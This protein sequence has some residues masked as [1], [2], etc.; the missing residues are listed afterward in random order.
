KDITLRKEGERAI[1][2]SE[3]RFKAIFEGAGMGI[4]MIDTYGK[5]IES[6]QALEDFLGYSKKELLGRAIIDFVHPDDRDFENRHFIFYQGAYNKPGFF[7]KRYLKRD[8]S[9]VWG[10]LTT[11]VIHDDKGVAE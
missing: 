2:A 9:V 7:E 6:N 3:L 4:A 10:K 5:L 8:G 11:T 1:K